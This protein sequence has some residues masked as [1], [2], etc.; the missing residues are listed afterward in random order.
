MTTQVVF[1]SLQF[2]DGTVGVLNGTDGASGANTDGTQAV[3]QSDATFYVVSSAV[4]NQFPGRTIT[5]ASISAGT[6][7]QYAYVLSR[8]GTVAALLPMQSRASMSDIGF[9]PLCRPYVLKSGDT[10]QTMTRA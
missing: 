9:Q 7:L 5:A 6:V 8:E 10:I 4:G 1:G 3:L 2:A